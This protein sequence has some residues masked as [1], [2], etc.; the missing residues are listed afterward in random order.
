M[1][2]TKFLAIVVLAIVSSTFVCHA[3]YENYYK[4]DGE[5]YVVTNTNTQLY[6]LPESYAEAVATGNAFGYGVRDFVDIREVKTKRVRKSE[7]LRVLRYTNVSKTHDLDAVIVAY[8]DKLWVLKSCDV[9][10]NTL[11]DQQNAKMSLDKKELES[12][13]NSNVEKHRDLTHRRIE[14]NNEIDSLVAY[15]TQICADSVSY[16]RNLEVRLPEIRDSLVLAAERAEQTRVDKEYNSWYNALPASSK[17]AANVITIDYAA[18]DYPNSAGGCDYNFEYTNLSPKTIKYLYW[19]GTTYNAVD[20]PVYCKIRGKSTFSG[21]DTG[22][23]EQGESGGGCWDC[24]IYNYTAEYM[25]L[26]KI[27]IIYMDGSTMNIGAADIARLF[28]APSREVSVDTWAIRRSVISERDCQS[29][30]AL[31]SNRLN[32]LQS[33]EQYSGQWAELESSSYNQTLTS[34]NVLESQEK[35]LQTE[36]NNDERDID[37]FNKF[38]NFEQFATANQKSATY[39]SSSYSNSKSTTSVNKKSPFV[40]FGVKGSLEGLNSLSAGCGLSMRVGRYSSLF[41]ATFGAKYQRTVYK[42]S[43]SYSYTDNLG[44][45]YSYANYMRDV[46][47]VVFPVVLNWNIARADTFSFY[48]G[49]GYEYGI[50]VSDTKGFEYDFGDIFNVSD[51]YAHS[52]DEFVQLS[53]P[54]R[55]SIIQIGFAGRSYDWK[56]YYKIHQPNSQLTNQERGAIGTAFIYYF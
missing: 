56:I 10:D 5:K 8:K 6:L 40:T 45:H 1:R 24:I 54:T 27:Q 37:A 25:K 13:Y 55:S 43:V 36:I 44:Y 26:S 30:M 7:K 35:L 23:I 14:L 4:V 18:L 42:E 29:K 48:V 2:F 41:N 53:V 39:S 22:P 49:V 19:T 47:Q 32:S 51:F 9:Q 34:L 28:T 3:Q 52:D 46:G 50:L 21:K 15:Y 31:W 20:D 12:K 17:V 11:L 16:Y 38:V 33:R